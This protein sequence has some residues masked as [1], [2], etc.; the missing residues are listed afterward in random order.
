MFF[1]ELCDFGAGLCDRDPFVFGDGGAIGKL[2]AREDSGDRIVVGRGDGIR[3]VIVAAGAG[4][5]DAKKGSSESID[6]FFPFVGDSGF[7]NLGRKLQLFPVCGAQAEKSQ[8]G[9]VG[10][11]RFGEQIGRQPGE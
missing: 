7:D 8:R 1:I 11:S 4:K 5:S 6:A 9:I 3:L 2:H 10:W